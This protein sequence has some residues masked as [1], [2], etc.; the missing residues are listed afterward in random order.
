MKGM[1]LRNMRKFIFFFE[2]EEHEKIIIETKM[3]NTR[4]FS[5]TQQLSV[6]TAN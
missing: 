3:L 2:R 5:L 4:T 6:N 1:K